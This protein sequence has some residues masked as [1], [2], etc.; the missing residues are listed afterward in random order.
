MMGDWETLVNEIFVILVSI[1][2]E[3]PELFEDAVDKH[4]RFYGR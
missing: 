3:S 4:I 1:S 2:N